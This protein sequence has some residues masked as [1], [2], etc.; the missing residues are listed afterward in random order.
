MPEIQCILF[1]FR[2]FS[3]LAVL[4]TVNDLSFLKHSPYLA[5]SLLSH[6][7]LSLNI[8]CRPLLLHL[9][10]TK[11]CL[12]LSLSLLHMLPFAPLCPLASVTIHMSL[13]IQC[14]YVTQTSSVGLKLGYLDDLLN[15]LTCLKVTI[16]LTCP[17]PNIPSFCTQDSQ[18]HHC[19]V[20][21]STP[22]TWMSFLVLLPNSPP[23][24]TMEVCPFGLLNII[25]TPFQSLHLHWFSSCSDTTISSLDLEIVS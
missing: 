11:L 14:I 4:G 9:S 19:P 13:T 3:L 17:K 15:F 16:K 24:V 6:Q 22:E 7:P 8:L 1:S 2:Q 20:P 23:W 10:I 21:L 25:L 5:F 18:W 12:L